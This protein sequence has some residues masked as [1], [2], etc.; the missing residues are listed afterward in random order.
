MQLKVGWGSSCRQV[1][2]KQ[3]GKARQD[4]GRFT[5]DQRGNECKGTKYCLLGVSR[6]T[7]GL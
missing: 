6:R 7:D 1:K 3:L 4:T 5:A 2:R